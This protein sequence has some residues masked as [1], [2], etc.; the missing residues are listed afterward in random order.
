MRAN[1]LLSALLAA[2]MVFGLLC[3]PASAA[4]P[5]LPAEVELGLGPDGMWCD[6][7]ESED[8]KENLAVKILYYDFGEDGVCTKRTQAEDVV[9]PRVSY[10]PLGVTFTVGPEFESDYIMAYSDPDGDGVYEQRLIRYTLVDRLLSGPEAVDLSE[11]GP[12]EG[13]ESVSYS[14]Y[15]EWCQGSNWLG[16]GY[17]SAYRTV[18]TDLLV[19]LYGAD[20]IIRF[21]DEPGE[22][23]FCWYLTGHERGAELG[24]D[25]L[26]NYGLSVTAS[27]HLTSAWAKDVVDRAV[28]LAMPPVYVDLAHNF[29][30]RG[31]VTRGE[32]AG[33]A[34][35]LYSK[36]GG[37]IE[38]EPG[39]DEVPFVDV[40]AGTDMG[41]FIL[42]AWRLDIVKGTSTTAKTFEPNK[43]VS[44]QEAALMLSRVFEAVGGEIPAGASTTFADNGEISS[45]AMDAVAFMSAKG[46]I[47]G[48]GANRFD[49]KGNAS[50]EQA[51]KIAVEMLDKLDV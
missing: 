5:K 44:R 34:M 12:F 2:A 43:P 26:E 18:T 20:T 17:M 50:V 35:Q 7:M 49:P 37:V 9:F 28:K 10:A 51:L 33:I 16:T 46:I 38:E 19:E 30:F 40:E 6:L 39:D 41:L 42:D 11:Q 21:C 3:A 4:A 48:V 24:D 47:N 31:S 23:G 14:N 27:G 15:L 29:D 25:K 32:F 45:W 8:V 13:S 22:K 1:K 36:L